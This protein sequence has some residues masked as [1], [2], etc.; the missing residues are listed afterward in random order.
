MAALEVVKKR[1]DAAGG[2]R[3]RAGVVYL[4]R[5]IGRRT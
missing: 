3:W 4:A 5:S 1:L 2:R